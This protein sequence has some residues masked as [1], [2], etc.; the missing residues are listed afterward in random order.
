[1]RMHAAAAVMPACKCCRPAKPMTRWTA[2]V[3]GCRRPE[4]LPSEVS[5]MP[6]CGLHQQV[7]KS[8]VLLPRR[9]HLDSLNV[10]WRLVSC[11]LQPPPFGCRTID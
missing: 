3:N 5:S 8:A 10:W 4:N 11:M 7:G 9:P 1:M 6:S 2:V